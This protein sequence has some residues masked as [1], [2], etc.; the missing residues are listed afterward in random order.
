[1]FLSLILVVIYFTIIQAYYIVDS[2]KEFKKYK[3]VVYLTTT[4]GLSGTLIATVAF[5]ITVSLSLFGC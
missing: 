2:Y 1:M 5:M 3:N 4:A